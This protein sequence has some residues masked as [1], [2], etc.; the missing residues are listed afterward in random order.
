VIAGR[1]SD[2][3]SHSTRNATLRPMFAAWAGALKAVDPQRAGQPV[4]R[5]E[6]F[7]GRGLT[8]RDA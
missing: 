1:A 7:I 5:A 8:S 4:G 2:S 6:A 3:G